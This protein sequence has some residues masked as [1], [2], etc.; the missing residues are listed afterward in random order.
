VF[1]QNAFRLRAS[2]RAVKLTDEGKGEVIVIQPGTVVELRGE[3]GIPAALKV[4]PMDRNFVCSWKICVTGRNS[5]T[6]REPR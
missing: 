6:E 3:S 5:L 1:S 4:C 2:V